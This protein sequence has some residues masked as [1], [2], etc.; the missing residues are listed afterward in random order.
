M[1]SRIFSFSLLASVLLFG[2][3]KEETIL[4][5]GVNYTGAPMVNFNNY[6][7][8][9]KIN[10]ELGDKWIPFDYEVK[11]T[12]TTEPAKN[13]IKVTIQK[14]DNP[15]G[16]Y[17][18]LNGT[19]LVTIPIN[20]FK[21]ENATITI[22]KGARKATFHFE[23]NP[24]KLNLANTYGFGFSILSVSG[25]GAVVNAADE[26]TRML[27]ELGTLNKMDGVYEFRSSKV[28]DVNRANLDPAALMNTE[29]FT[30]HLITSGGDN[31][32][33]WWASVPGVI[34]AD[35]FARPLITKPFGLSSYFEVEPKYVFS[36]ALDKVIAVVN[37]NPSLTRSRTLEIIGTNNP[38]TF[39]GANPNKIIVSYKMKQP[40]FIDVLCYDTLVYIKKR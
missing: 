11:L 2:C 31:N 28:I 17:N 30:M 37:D 10:V 13:D 40:G 6:G 8:Y 19:N 21:I 15:L 3:K 32:K 22:P 34:N 35:F 20:A 25:G 9:Q 14:D 33:L 27:I 12:N 1:L 36:P 38:V 5:K 26:E 23:I 16:E 39:N 4:E 18:T 24:A 7:G 29:L